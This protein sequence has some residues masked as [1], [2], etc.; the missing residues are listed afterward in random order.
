M[1]ASSNGKVPRALVVAECCVKAWLRLVEEKDSLGAQ[2][3]PSKQ[4]RSIKDIE[5]DAEIALVDEAQCRMNDKDMFGVDDLEGNEV[6]VDVREKI[7]EKE[8][9]TADP[10]NTVGEVVT[11]A[12]VEDNVAPTTITTTDVDDE[13]TLAKTLIAIN[14]TKPRVIL[15][16]A[17]T[18]TTI[19]TTPRA[20]E[21]EKPL[22]KKD[23]ISLDE[24]VVRK[25]EAEMKA[26]MKKEERIA[27]EKD[28]EN[29]AVIE[30]WD[31]ASALRRRR[32]V[33]IQ[34]PEETATSVIMHTENDVMEQVKRS[35]RQNNAVMRY[36]ALKR[37]PL[38]EAQE[39]KNMMIYIKNM[40]DFKMN[41]FKGMTYSEIRPLFEKHCNSNQAFLEKVKEEVTV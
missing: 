19:I 27:R 14:T 10:V 13:L 30:E 23:Q 28:K 9:S 12:S 16:A 21:L 37:K 8:V 24:E 17:T 3:D 33:V 32:G 2:E 39:R 1:I 11:A 22:K 34:D 41:F 7:I 40:A 5:Q 29:R 31:D 26:K 4:E 35:K 38:T 20:K 25:I 15:T 36:Q 6:I 18:V